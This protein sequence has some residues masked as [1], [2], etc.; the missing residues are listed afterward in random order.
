MNNNLIAR[1]SKAVYLIVILLFLYFPLMVVCTF[2]FNEG[3]STASWSGFTLDWYTGLLTNESLMK[4][5]GV[6]LILS[7]TVT[8]ISVVAGVLCGIAI[9]KFKNKFTKFIIPL[10][11]LPVL[12]PEIIV[13]IAFMQ[14]FSTL[15]LKF[16]MLTLILSHLSFCVPFV[17][18]V[19]L[20]RIQSITANVE[21]A[22]RDLGATEWQAFWHITVPELMPGIISGAALAFIMSFDDV[23]I[24]F[25]M[26]GAT[27]TTLPVKVYSMLR[28]GVSPEINAL[29]TLTV[30]L[31]AIC[32]CVFYI[33]K[34]NNGK[35]F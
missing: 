11:H 1:M 25:F 31:T 30:V 35:E 17:I 19:V 10:V 16:G 15:N 5:L 20:A 4:T 28:V 33:N 27:N 29:T 24:S 23:I 34:L 2:S 32:V 6:S 13:G 14:I 12:T 21:D 7:I 9:H 26:S 18:I 22:A 8:V 3:K